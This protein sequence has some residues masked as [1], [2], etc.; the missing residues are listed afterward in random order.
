M[1]AYKI[2][3]TRG[4]WIKMFNPT[5]VFYPLD[6]RPDD[7]DIK[8][9]AWSLSMQCRFNGNINAF[10]SL[11]QHSVVV[12]RIVESEHPF[13][14]DLVLHALLHDAHEAYTGDIITPIKTQFGAIYEI[15]ERLD[16]VIMEVFGLEPKMP[17][18]VR[19][20]DETAL[21]TEMRDLHTDPYLGEKF[22]HVKPLD[23][24]IEPV[25]H[26]EAYNMFMRRFEDLQERR[27]FTEWHKEREAAK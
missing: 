17:D 26:K 3:T 11:A 9:I 6:P 24:V 16:R 12:S 4:P 22:A 23:Y 19:R 27:R 7:I 1:T 14:N 2:D 10:Y 13:D 20:A 25:G 15:E 21:V 8:N 5:R 18:A